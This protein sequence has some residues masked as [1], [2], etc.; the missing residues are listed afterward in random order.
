MD[1]L[2]PL[3]PLS[4]WSLDYVE[5]S[6]G[7]LGADAIRPQLSS[8]NEMCTASV[9][10]NSAMYLSMLG[11]YRLEDPEVGPSQL[12]SILSLPSNVGKKLALMS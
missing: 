6:S 1:G 4:L 5:L 9:C 2:W 3:S 7:L 12:K 8:W 11:H 10:L